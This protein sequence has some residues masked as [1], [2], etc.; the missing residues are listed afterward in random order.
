MLVKENKPMLANKICFKKI[1]KRYIQN[2]GKHLLSS[3]NGVHRTN[4]LS[5]ILDEYSSAL[6]SISESKVTALLRRLCMECPAH[7]SL[8]LG[9][10]TTWY[11]ITI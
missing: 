3:W 2:Q 1:L 11:S 6:E 4:L 8:S 7:N 5:Q 10:F 9:M